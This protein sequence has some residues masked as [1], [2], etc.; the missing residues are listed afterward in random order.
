MDR[1]AISAPSPLPS[2]G[3]LSPLPCHFPASPHGAEMGARG[4]LA[5][6]RQRSRREERPQRAA[7][8]QDPGAFTLRQPLLSALLS[9][10]PLA[11]ADPTC[12]AMLREPSGVPGCGTGDRLVPL[13]AGGMMCSRR[14]WAVTGGTGVPP[15]CTIPQG[16]GTMVAELG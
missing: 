14:H 12:R 4:W 1:H 13:H 11:T 6:R 2:L 15:G 3:T 7:P 16:K 10:S 5:E 8:L 9:P